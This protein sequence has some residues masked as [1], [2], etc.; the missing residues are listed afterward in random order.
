MVDPANDVARSLIIY[1][2]LTLMTMLALGVGI[3]F[4]LISF[5]RCGF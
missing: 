3:R 4:F 5:Y 2:D 1:H